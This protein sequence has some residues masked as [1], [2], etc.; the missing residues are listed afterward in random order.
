MDKGEKGEI[1]NIGNPHEFTLLELADVV[2]RLTNSTSEVQIVESLPAD[3]PL[4][5]CPDITKARER[6][7]WEPKVELEEG[8]R[9][10]IDYLRASK[11]LNYESLN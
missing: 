5:R 4:R 7:G 10:T 1:Y 3:D 6:L 11:I 8:L 2:K 9:K